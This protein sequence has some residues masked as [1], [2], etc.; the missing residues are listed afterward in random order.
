MRKSFTNFTTILKN[1]VIYFCCVVS[2]FWNIWNQKW[3]LVEMTEFCE[4]LL[5]VFRINVCFLVNFF[6][7][8]F[9]DGVLDGTVS[10]SWILEFISSFKILF[11]S[12]SDCW[13]SSFSILCTS[14]CFINSWRSWT[15]WRCG[16]GKL[17]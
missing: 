17:T 2:R 5:K 16:S 11:I 9:I 10:S 6:G 15:T 8:N 1:S 3:N 14:S 12:P 13:S 7:R 4:L